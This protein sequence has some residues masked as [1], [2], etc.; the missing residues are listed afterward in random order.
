MAQKGRNMLQTNNNQLRVSPYIRCISLV[1][2]SVIPCTLVNRNFLYPDHKNQIN[3]D[4]HHPPLFCKIHFNIILPNTL[5][6]KSDFFFFQ[7]LFFHPNP[8][9][10]FRKLLIHIPQRRKQWVPLKCRTHLPN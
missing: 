5:V 4:H 7:I 10:T 3:L 6:L 2:F 1:S 8:I 9:F